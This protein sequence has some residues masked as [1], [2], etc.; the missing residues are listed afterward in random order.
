MCS[1]QA[2]LTSM[3]N[4][5]VN[6]FRINLSHGTAEDKK[7]Y[8]NLIRSIISDYDKTYP[9]ILA[10]L[11]GPKV[12]VMNL[13]KPI[14]LE[15]DQTV[16][17]SSEKDGPDIIPVSRDLSFGSIAKDAKIMID[18]GRI[19]LNIIKKVSKGTFECKTIIPGEIKSR[20]GVN[21]LG[22]TLSIPTLTEQD[23]IDLE[24][25]LKNGADW[26]ALSFTRSAED[27]KIVQSRIIDLGYDVPIMAK[28]E[29]WEAI[30]NLDDIIRVFDGI[31]V[32]RGDLGV[33]LPLERVPIIQKEIIKKAR[34]AGKPVVVATQILESMIQLPA[35]TRAEVSDIANS[36]LD[37][38]DALLV[39]GETAIGQHPGKVIDVLSSVIKETEKSIH[40][41]S[42]LIDNNINR[43]ISNAISHAACSI[44]HDLDLD[45]IVT[46]TQSGAT[47]RFVSSFRPFSKII[48]MT[49]LIKTFRQLSI[50]WG[51]EAIIVPKYESSDEI[52]GL[53]K[54]VLSE[55]NIET[56]NDKFI[57]TGGVPVNVPGTT[58]FISVLDNHVQA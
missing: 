41:S 17:V 56:K 8:F 35:P 36:I 24:L 7:S 49:T 50:I 11:A 31:M 18:D 38:A 1:N 39:T 33:E 13:D 20:K 15:K 46:M 48:A 58:N 23:K 28:I 42:E 10:D 14:R 30:E 26:I 54:K 32:A 51:I 55:M 22:I 5:G 21:F 9:T 47:A 34:F 19:C 4:S 43:G 52:P 44:A 25:A 57:I 16:L 3:V 45:T 37:G 27:Y 12:R 53:A 40:V 2:L 6:C 29:K